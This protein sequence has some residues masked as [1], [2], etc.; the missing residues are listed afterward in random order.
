MM[1]QSDFKDDG[2]GGE[3]TLDGMTSIINEATAGLALENMEL[4]VNADTIQQ[5]MVFGRAVEKYVE[6]EAE[7]GQTWK[8]FDEADAAHHCVHKAARMQ[9]TSQPGTAVPTADG[10]AERTIQ[11]AGL[12]SAIDIMNYGA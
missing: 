2:E 3:R 12:D 6:R 10:E 4:P 11:A 5:M 7:Y 1:G 8:Q 9:A